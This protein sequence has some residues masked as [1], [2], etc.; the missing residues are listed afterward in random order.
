MRSPRA[1]ARAATPID[2]RFGPLMLAGPAGSS[3]WNYHIGAASSGLDNGTATTGAPDHDFDGD[4]R[5]QGTGTRVWIAV[6]TR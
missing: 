4:A 5:P 6:P 1:L 3:A 2:V